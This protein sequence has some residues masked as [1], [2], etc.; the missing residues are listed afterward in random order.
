LD[1]ADRQPF[2]GNVA[3]PSHRLASQNFGPLLA[4]R[5]CHNLDLSFVKDLHASDSP[6]PATPRAGGVASWHHGI[7]DV[8]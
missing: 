8:E 6:L 7:F 1:F 4:G 2:S 3:K 5:I